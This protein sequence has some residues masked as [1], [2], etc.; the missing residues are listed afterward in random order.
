V[1]VPRG[2]V[3]SK[4]PSEKKEKPFK[5]RFYPV[6]M[7]IVKCIQLFTLSTMLFQNYQIISNSKFGFLYFP[8]AMISQIQQKMNE[9]NAIF[10]L[11]SISF[12]LLI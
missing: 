6:I 4:M 9:V 2:G 8:F 5:N 7:F 11:G 3:P 12:N 10:Y 1:G